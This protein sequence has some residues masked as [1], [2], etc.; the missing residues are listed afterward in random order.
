M[1]NSIGLGLGLKMRKYIFQ[2]V[3]GQATVCIA[4]IFLEV[5]SIIMHIQKQVF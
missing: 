3:W 2:D 4:G 1:L 5:V